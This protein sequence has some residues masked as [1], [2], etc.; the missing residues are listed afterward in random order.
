VQSCIPP[1]AVQFHFI[2]W[3]FIGKLIEIISVGMTQDERTVVVECDRILT[4]VL[5]ILPSI[6]RAYTASKPSSHPK[7]KGLEIQRVNNL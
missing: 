5:S 4:H 6:L 3:Q 2:I 7:G 1:G